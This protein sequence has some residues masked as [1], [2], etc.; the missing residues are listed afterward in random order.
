M[1]EINI[2]IKLKNVNKKNLD[3]NLLESDLKETLM[4]RFESTAKYKI[5]VFADAVVVQDYI[6]NNFD[7]EMNVIGVQYQGEYYSV[8]ALEK[9]LIGQFKHIRTVQ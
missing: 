5:T 2:T 9:K 1:L 4:A 6:K 8:D 7:I 3:I